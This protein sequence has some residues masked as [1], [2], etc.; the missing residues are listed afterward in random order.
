MSLR[1]QNCLPGAPS[2]VSLITGDLDAATGFYG[3]LLGWEFEEG[4]AMERWGPYLRA[5]VCG[6]PV[7]GLGAAA[8]DV[9]MPVSWTTYFGVTDADTCASAVRERGG[10][11]AVGPLTLGVG[12]LALAADPMGAGFGLWECE[13]GEGWATRRPLDGAPTWLEL[14]T[15]DAFD[16]A[17][18]YGGVFGWD[19]AAQDLYDVRYEEDRVVLA[20]DGRD[21]AG[22]YGGAV[23]AAADPQVRPRWNVH[24][25][26]SDVDAAAS[27]AKELG[28][29]VITEPTDLSYGRTAGL[30]DTEGALFHLIGPKGD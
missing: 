11:V 29:A 1:N 12:R 16:A 30:R 3:E 4:P 14:R 22:M 20:V 8:R 5:H 6:V 9:E 18:F 21:M 17:L 10:T 13:E 2:W 15:R 24:F 27:R 23:E 7:A 19:R 28:G 26:V 25:Q